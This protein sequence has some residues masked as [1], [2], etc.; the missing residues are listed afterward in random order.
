MSI[1]E[2]SRPQ[3]HRRW[4]ALGFSFAF[5]IAT[6]IFVFRVI[7]KDFFARLLATQDRGLLAAAAGFMLWQMAL[8][9]E[10]WRRRGEGDQQDDHGKPRQPRPARPAMGV[11]PILSGNAGEH[12]RSQGS[13]RATDRRGKRSR[14]SAPKARAYLQIG[15]ECVTGMATR[16]ALPTTSW[17]LTAGRRAATITRRGHERL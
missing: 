14:G 15:Q 1:Q 7:D 2:T 10:R 3:A 5:T 8:G 4:L 17:P 6:L 9:G 16:H 13:T 11:P 12:V